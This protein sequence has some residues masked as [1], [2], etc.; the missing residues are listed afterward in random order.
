MIQK[1][2]R[3]N[4]IRKSAATAVGAIVL[5]AIVPARVLAGSGKMPPSDKIN[6]GFIGVGNMGTGH[7][8]SF[9][10]YDDVHVAAVCDVRKKHRD[11]AKKIVD[12]RYGSTDCDTYH[13]FREL[14][15]RGDIDAIVMA[16]PDHWHALIGIEAAKQNKD[17]YHEKPLSLFFRECQ[18][19]RKAVND[20]GV[21][22]Q[23]G[24]QQRSD[25]RFRFTC[26][27][28]RNEKFGKLETIVVAS[29]G[30]S[31]S[32]IIRPVEPV[33]PGFDYDMWLGPAPWAPH[34][35]LRT[36]RSFTVI[37]DYSV[38]CISGAYGIHHVD[39]AQWA[40]DA[41]HTGPISV[42]GQG[43]V[44]EDGLFDTITSW[45]SEQTYAS[46]VK[47]LHMDHGTA[48]KRF[49]Q[50]RGHAMGMLF[51]GSEG[52]VHVK[53]GY[54]NAQPES[55]LKTVIGPDEIRLPRSNDHRRNFLDCVRSRRQT[56]SP[57]ETAVRSEA[58]AQQ[59]DI[60]IRLGR[61]LEWDPVREEFPGDPEANKKLSRPMRS[62]W[63][64]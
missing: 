62:P 25:E 29:A 13:D 49:P 3:R 16:T 2:N 44:P 21:V 48:R 39:I 30:G 36:T 28:A 59:A 37:Y 54:I 58:V 63:H 19:M 42:E 9:L 5:P 32:N 51:I 41:D 52:W 55:L 40:A 46:G 11:R 43:V 33:P 24:T 38:G 64:L 61:R 27:L 56:V 45:E 20:S 53:R 22:F 1:F 60:A 4:F 31:G 17:M 18:A 12:D 10:G 8:R 50:L 47:L 6:L 7:V 34:C 57:I 15:A 14:L 35:N 23:L 26:E